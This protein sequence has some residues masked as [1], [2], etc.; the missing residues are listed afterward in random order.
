MM[1]FSTAALE[2]VFTAVEITVHFR[3]AAH[4]ICV[5]W[6]DGGWA[7]VAQCLLAVWSSLTPFSCPYEWLAF[8]ADNT[9][10]LLKRR[11]TVLT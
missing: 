7:Q 2:T 10:N 4:I 3:I 8:V 1:S 5:T 11:V 6:V 9:S